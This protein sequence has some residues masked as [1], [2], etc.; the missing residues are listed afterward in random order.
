MDTN[1]KLVFENQVS[2]RS[3][4]CVST[5]SGEY[6]LY[7]AAADEK[8]QD[9]PMSVSLIDAQGNIKWEEKYFGTDDEYS[10]A[11]S[12]FFDIKGNIV[13]LGY[14]WKYINGEYNS[15]EFIA[16]LDK[17]GKLLEE[18]ILDKVNAGNQS[19][20]LQALDESEFLLINTDTDEKTKK[21]RTTHLTKLNDKFEVVWKK[22]LDD[23]PLFTDYKTQFMML[24]KNKSNIYVVS[25]KINKNEFSIKKI[26]TSGSVDWEKTFTK[27][28]SIENI[29]ETAK[30]ELVLC[31]NF[32]NKLTVGNTI[33][34]LKI[35]ATGQT[36][37]EKEIKSQYE[38]HINAI[39]EAKDNE[40]LLGGEGFGK[41]DKGLLVIKVNGL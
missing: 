41:N 6:L 7:G 32:S 4:G 1:G 19:R 37:W 24:D 38:T 15:K 28:F 29:T 33:Y 23:E 40:Y 5:P 21:I 2:L 11:E 16:V 9:Y 10:I 14:R 20:S 25:N 34:L 31:G 17:N 39:L 35:D 30:G 22:T 3:Q 18:K 8:K 36:I 12:A 26:S 13:I 27:T